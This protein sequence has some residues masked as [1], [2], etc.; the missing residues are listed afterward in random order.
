MAF[1]D[2]DSDSMEKIEEFIREQ[3]SNLEGKI[4]QNM[5]RLLE[6]QEESLLTK[7][8]KLNTVF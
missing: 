5:R 3:N 7:I 1:E 6:D 2:F 8:D 4:L